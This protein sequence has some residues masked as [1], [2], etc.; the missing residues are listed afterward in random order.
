[1]PTGTVAV[2]VKRLTRKMPLYKRYE[3][4]IRRFE[5]RTFAALASLG[6]ALCG[7]T[8]QRIGFDR[9]ANEFVCD[10]PIPHRFAHKRRARLFLDGT[11][12]RGRELGEDY[13]LGNIRFD[14]GDII[15]DCGANI[16]DLGL[17]F[18]AIRQKVRMI[19]FE[20]SPVEYGLLVK[21]LEANPYIEPIGVHNVALWERTAAGIDFFVKSQTADSSIIP[22]ADFD[23][24][25]TVS[26]R[27]LDEVLSRRPYRLLKL[28]AEGA[29]PEILRGATGV[30]D[31]FDYVTVD[32]GFERGVKQETTAPEVTR[33]LFANGFELIDLTP[34]RVTLLFRRIGLKDAS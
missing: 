28:E 22:I 15:V 8:R 3:R 19:G 30:L 26:C 6:S 31:C 9:A 18:A 7:Q 27:R 11:L 10:G 25:I 14:D 24:K 32:A 5:G 20:P 13:L 33:F 21:N 12:A 34:K 17:Y 4:M 23:Q 1:M 29:E 2:S 16:G